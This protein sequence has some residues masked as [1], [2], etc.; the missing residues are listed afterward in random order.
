[1]AYINPDLPLSGIKVL[2]LSAYIAGPYGCTL[3]GDMGA[4]VIKIESPEGDN[5]RR[6]PSTLPDESRAFLGINRGKRGVALDLKSEFGHEALCRLVREADVLVHNFRPSV[7][8]RLK[9]DYDRMRAINPR[10]VYCALTGYGQSGPLAHKAGYDQV[11]Q[12]RTGI[13]ASQGSKQEPQIVYGSVVDYYASTMLC[14]SVTAALYQRE[15]TG[16]GSRISVSLLA[17]ALAMQAARL[18]MTEDEPRDINR[19]M[20]SGGITGI[21]PTQKGHLYISANTPHFWRALC[22]L[23]GVP[24]LAHTEKY[25]SVRKRAQFADEIVPVI[26]QALMARTALEWEELFAAE[27]PCSAVRA[28]EDMFEDPQVLE[29]GLIGETDHPGVGKYRALAVPFKFGASCADRQLIAAPLLG[30]HTEEVL[31]ALGFDSKRLEAAFQA[32]DILTTPSSDRSDP[33]R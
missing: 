8:S 7:P 12:A 2:D 28:T 17:S 24:H 9:V 14:S 20:R 32:G 21:Y 15:R 33:N 23:A 22:E 3:L 30:Q 10:L 11:L 29:Q 26:R 16:V 5:L 4:S 13:C 18:V 6:Y 1:M 25:D 27:V 31:G 19:D